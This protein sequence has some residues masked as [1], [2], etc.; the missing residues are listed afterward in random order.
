[1]DGGLDPGNVGPLV[2]DGLDLV[3]A[4]SAVFDG[5][6]PEARCGEMLAALARSRTVRSHVTRS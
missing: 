6:D 4:G 5:K 3:V 2:E 1:M